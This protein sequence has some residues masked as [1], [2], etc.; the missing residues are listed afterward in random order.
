MQP[1]W[2]QKLTFPKEV[3]IHEEL[4]LSDE[5]LTFGEYTE[6]LLNKYYDTKP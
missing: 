5:V 3:T 2:D 4:C 6:K 1:D